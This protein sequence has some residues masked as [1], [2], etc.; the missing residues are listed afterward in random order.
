[1]NT[2][3]VHS[4]QMD[5]SRASA[6]SS[7]YDQLI[8]TLCKKGLLALDVGASGDCFFRAISYQYYG[9]PEFHIAVRQ[10]GVNYLEQHPDPGGVR[11]TT[12]MVFGRN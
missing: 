1:M 5:A 9:T 2:D 7:S 8:N 10:A 3:N 11:A 6:E 4:S 12:T